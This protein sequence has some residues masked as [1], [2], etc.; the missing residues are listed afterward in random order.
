MNLDN[1]TVE[2]RPRTE[3]EAADL[4]ARMV[5]RDTRTIYATWFALT[6][7]LFALACAV[8]WFSSYPSLASIGFWW[9]EPLTDGRFGNRLA[10][11][12]D[13]NFH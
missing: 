9:L 3:W 10:K 13:A 8:I 11:R 5:R 2:L 4:G 7:P 12:R 1:V 6:L